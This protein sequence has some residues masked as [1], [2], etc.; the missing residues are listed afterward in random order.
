MTRKRSV[1]AIDPSLRE[2]GFA[3]FRARELVDY[4]VKSL[5]RPGNAPKRIAILREVVKRLIKLKQPDV[6]VMEDNPFSYIQQN[7]S[8]VIATLWIKELASSAKVP[9]R[10]FAPSTIKELVTGDDRATK[11][12]VTSVLCAQ[13]PE[14]KFYRECNRSWRVRYYQNMFD[15]VACGFTY[16]RLY[17]DKRLH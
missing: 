13:F 1:I 7:Q 16:I 4:G 11:R 12:R 17:E 8:L 14:L 15:A 6:L 2:T 5:R 9:V 10:E 3:H